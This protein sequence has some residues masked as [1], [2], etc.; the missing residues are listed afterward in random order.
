MALIDKHKVEKNFIVLCHVKLTQHKKEYV[1]QFEKNYDFARSN[2]MF[3]REWRLR[4][5]L[6]NLCKNMEEYRNFMV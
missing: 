2:G 1:L 4:L 5:Y 6:K 3:P